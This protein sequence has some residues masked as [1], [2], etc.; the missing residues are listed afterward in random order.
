MSSEAQIM[1]SASA[2]G[3][4]PRE[5]SSSAENEPEPKRIKLEG[6]PVPVDVPREV[7]DKGRTVLVEQPPTHLDQTNYDVLPREAYN[8]EMEEWDQLSAAGQIRVNH[9]MRPNSS[10]DLVFPLRDQSD[11]LGRVAPQF[12]DDEGFLHQDVVLKDAVIGA[13]FE[14]LH[15]Q[16]TSR[17]RHTRG[18][19]RAAYDRVLREFNVELKV[20]MDNSRPNVTRQKSSFLAERAE[21]RKLTANELK[22]HE[23]VLQGQFGLFRRGTGQAARIE[24]IGIYQ[25]ARI[26]RGASDRQEKNRQP[27]YGRYLI[28]AVSI[29]RAPSIRTT[30][31]GAGA[32]NATGFANTAL[33]PPQPNQPAAFHQSRINSLFV[34]VEATLTTKLNRETKV[35]F[36]ALVGLNL[37]PGEQILVDY[38]D[39]FL[40]HFNA[41]SSG[42]SQVPPAV[43]QEPDETRLP[44]RPQRPGTPP[45][46]REGIA[47]FVRPVLE[48]YIEVKKMVP[49]SIQNITDALV[50]RIRA[51][52]KLAQ[53]KVAA[54]L[55]TERAE[56]AA[57]AGEKEMA[58]VYEKLRSALEEEVRKRNVGAGAPR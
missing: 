47:N 48:P 55:L 41:P 6:A 13:L 43:K 10:L 3:Q 12:S 27:D 39:D 37:K 19:D 21:T 16:T 56:K 58:N 15:W 30:Y 14:D 22:P 54:T 11:P 9:Q 26:H 40:P 25:G 45:E 44:S 35:V 1:S 7:A 17:T 28:D 20:L 36:A 38:G 57:K 49:E 33:R 34:P 51:S 32:S 52:P 4:A 5:R 8:I 23:K 31:S 2:S 29:R 46:L 24:L 18:I 53:E 50:E 42:P